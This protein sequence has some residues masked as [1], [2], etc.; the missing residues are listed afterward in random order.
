MKM[1]INVTENCNMFCDYCYY[2]RKNT[3]S[4]E[5]DTIKAAIEMSTRHDTSTG[6]CFFGGEPLLEKGLIE[7]TL[8]YAAA[9]HKK[10]GHK[11]FFKINTNGTLL[12]E[13]FLRLARTHN[14]VIAVS[15][16]GLMREG[17]RRYT[18]TVDLSA[19]KLRTLLHYQPY[20]FVMTTVN[21]LSVSL[22]ADSVEW[23]FQQGFRYLITSPAHGKHIFWDDKSCDMLQTQYEKLAQLYIKWTNMGE[24]FYLGA[25]E[26]KIASHIEGEKYARRHCHIGDDQI[27]VAVDGRIYPC[28]QF[29][30]N[31]DYCIGDVWV[32]IDPRLQQALVS[33]QR[34]SSLCRGCA[35]N[36]RCIHACGCINNLDTGSPDQVSPFQC[37]HE[38]TLISIVDKTAEKLYRNKNKRFIAKHYDPSYPLVSLIEDG[39]KKIN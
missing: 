38:K 11:F 30:G 12:D 31:P 24:K 10:T 39:L 21:P 4:A 28:V 8:D 35:I 25:F 20:A 34:E 33:C 14:I 5:F 29:V 9:I 32:G 27:S 37:R 1:T 23:L 22:F 13:S 16:D 36:N 6:V 17:G 3:T 26:T 2:R 15:H 7:T 19:E 18:D